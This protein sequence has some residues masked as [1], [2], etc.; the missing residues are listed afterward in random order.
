[1]ALGEGC[2]SEESVICIIY[3]DVRT[4]REEKRKKMLSPG[5]VKEYSTFC[6]EHSE[7]CA[8]RVSPDGWI[9]R[10]I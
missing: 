5:N 7:R 9:M 4:E 6:L 8:E 3:V 10:F 1:M 2:S